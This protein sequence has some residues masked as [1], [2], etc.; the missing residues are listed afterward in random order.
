MMIQNLQSRPE[1]RAWSGAA[2]P[3]VAPAAVFDSDGIAVLDSD[4]NPVLDSGT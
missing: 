3:P 1:P 2:A 4:G